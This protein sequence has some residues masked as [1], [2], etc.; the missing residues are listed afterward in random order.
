MDAPTSLLFGLDGFRVV[1]V[2]RVDDR[3][4]QVL[5]ET[6]ELSWACPE[7][8]ARSSRVK[9]RPMVGVKGLPASGQRVWLWWRKR[10]LVCAQAQCP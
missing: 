7:C 2:V 10:R 4:I 5:I 6:V 3:V 1:D 8:G 9:D